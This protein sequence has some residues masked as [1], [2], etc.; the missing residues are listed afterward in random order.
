ML[1]QTVCLSNTLKIQ[2]DLKDER[3]RRKL[4]TPEKEQANYRLYP[5][6]LKTLKRT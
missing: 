3:E 5:I 1:F 2:K 6:I 4:R